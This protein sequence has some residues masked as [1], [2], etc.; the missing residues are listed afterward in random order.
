MMAKSLPLYGI[1]IALA[2][3]IPP[4]TVTGEFPTVNSVKLLKAKNRPIRL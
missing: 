3:A 4:A 1:G 2:Y